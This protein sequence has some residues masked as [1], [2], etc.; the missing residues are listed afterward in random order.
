[1][2][3]WLGRTFMPD[4]HRDVPPPPPSQRAGGQRLIVEQDCSN[5]IHR[6]AE[7]LPCP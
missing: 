6:S 2:L 7:I 1:V 4:P 3:D 5:P